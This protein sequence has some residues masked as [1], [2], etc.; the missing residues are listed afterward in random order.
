VTRSAPLRDLRALAK[1]YGVQ[2]SFRDAT[3]VVRRASPDAL[4]RVVR[5]LGAPLDRV[6]DAGEAPAAQR[7]AGPT[8]NATATRAPR[9]D[10]T[11]GVFLP[12]YAVQ[13]ERGTGVGDLTDL[14]AL[15]RWTSKHGARVFGTLPLFAAFL[16]DPF[17]PSPYSPASRL[18]FNE[19]YVDVERTREFESNADVRELLGSRALRGEIALLRRQRNLD[20]AAAYRVKR[21]L[22]EALAATPS[23]DLDARL[24]SFEQR[25]PLVGRYAEFRSARETR[26]SVRGAG[27]R[28]ASERYH[29]Y[30][31]LVVHEQLDA[32]ASSEAGGGLLLDLPL[33]V[34]PEGF[35]IQAFPDAFVHGVSVGAP[36]D[37]FFAGGQ[38][39]GFPPIHPQRGIEYFRMVVRKL[40]R[41]AAV[42]RIDHV[43]GLH[44]QYWI[45]D[46]MAATEGVYVR[47]PADDLYA[48]VAEAAAE[49][50]TT[51]VGEDLGTVGRDVR[52]MMR[53]HGFLSTYVAQFSI[54]DDKRAPVAPPTRDQL[55]CINTHDTATFARFWSDLG[56]EHQRTL[57]RFLDAGDTDVL[58]PLLRF[59]ARSDAPV[60]L[61]NLEDLWGEME[62]Q[63]VPGTSSGEHPNWTRR[64][65]RTLEELT[66][67]DR[68]ARTL[69]DIARFRNGEDAA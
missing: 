43:M 4:A 17:E 21:R 39:W 8:S 65:A 7:E 23:A 59:L 42:V 50:G 56:A 37:G 62:P 64:A 55:A 9:P 18:F 19:L 26:G 24:A 46:G 68:I 63:N 61:V 54:R 5:A 31:Q 10:R 48:I 20:L 35:D 13:S 34:H 38:N 3:G 28:A 32:V 58:G 47:Y 36:P 49:H 52:P 15:M 16:D 30:A 1:S 69:D 60:V 27:D 22:L 44:R 53:K 2:L 51:V 41:T 67:D 14:E 12:L 45:P 57:K 29:R 40:M 6:E 11:W 25:E 66:T 33:G